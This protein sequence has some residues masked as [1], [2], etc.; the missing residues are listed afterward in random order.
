MSKNSMIR[1]T[2]EICHCGNTSDPHYFRHSF[3][4]TT[5]VERKSKNSFCIKVQ[6][7]PTKVGTKCSAFQCVALS[8]VHE[9]PTLE[10][11]FIPLEYTYRNVNFTLPEDTCC[12]VCDLELKNHTKV[13]TH[14]FTVNIKFENLGEN[15][16]LTISYPD[17]DDFKIKTIKL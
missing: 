7:F 14:I 8:S 1:H 3:V 5:I 10:H 17:D 9:T 16:I 6:D 15:D 13:M 4:K 2:Y 11:K 12:T